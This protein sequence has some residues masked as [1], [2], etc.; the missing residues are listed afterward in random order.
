MIRLLLAEDQRILLEALATLLALEADME[1]VATVESGEAIVPAALEH[2]PDV[3]VLDLDLPGIDGISAA[4]MLRERLPSCAV[5]ILTALARPAHLKRALAA[6]VG[7][8]LPKEATPDQLAAAIREVRAGGR[9][10]DQRLALAALQAP[11]SPLTP[12]EAEILRLLGSGVGAPKIAADLFL[13]EGTVRNYLASAVTK[14]NARNRVDA[15][16]IATEAG[17]L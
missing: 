10:V 15:V 3:A 1:V 16:R 9:V 2:R 8:F 14:L 12:R 6:G 7:G 17:W 4:A 5:V 11:D 13:S